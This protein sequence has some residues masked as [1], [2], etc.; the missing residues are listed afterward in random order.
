M[1]RWK[2]IY[3]KFCFD[4][5]RKSM[6]KIL[7]P[8]L[9]CG[10][11]LIGCSQPSPA[12]EAGQE[13][14]DTPRVTAPDSLAP[15]EAAENNHEED[16]AEQILARLIRDEGFRDCVWDEADIRSGD[17]EETIL[18]K[19]NQCERLVLKE[20]AANSSLHSLEALSYLPNL[21]SLVIDLEA[22]DDAAVAD[23]TPI[24]ALSGLQELELQS[25]GISDIGFLRELTQL[26]DINLKYNSITDI[27][28]LTGLTK[29][30]RLG[31]SENHIQDIS[32]LEMLTNLYDLALDG[33]E[34]R[35]ISAL[36]GME[37]LNQAGLSD[38]RISDLSPL[39]GKKELMY[40]SAAGNP[41]ADLQPVWEVPLLSFR[42]CE[43]TEEERKYAKAWMETHHPDV[44]DYTCM[45]YVEGD[46]NR[47]GRRDI[48]FV[49]DGTFGDQKHDEIYANTRRMYILIQQEDGSMEEIA[50]SPAISSGDSGGMRGDPYFGMFMGAGYLMVKEGW[51]SSTGMTVVQIYGYENGRLAQTKNICVGDSHFADSY[52][53]SVTDP[54]TDTWY[55]YTIVMD[56][57]RMV[58]VDL[59]ASE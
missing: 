57:F 50:E 10:L 29:L 41:C 21:K 22:W 54:E 13:H 33:N 23:F 2:N 1:L 5:F 12:R 56:G 15:P 58:R 49:I 39:A 26:R 48:A 20:P 28:P 47:D 55:E 4:N 53:V 14:G 37:H 34:I 19:L 17:T 52:E 8:A 11:F 31:L 18:G 3:I 59:T 7:A 6:G 24:A 42:S 46:L 51:G 36:R 25:C 32:P 27:S 45:D 35:D 44:T 38:N 40:V 43:A 30:E 9:L 16:S